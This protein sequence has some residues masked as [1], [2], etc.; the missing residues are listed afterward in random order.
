MNASVLSLWRTRVLAIALALV[1]AC[2]VSLLMVSTASAAAPTMTAVTADTNTDGTI[3]R[4]TITF[5]EAADLDD[6][7]AGDGFTSLALSAS[8]AI[9]NGDYNNDSTTTLTL[10]N[11]TGCTSE[12]TAITPT[13]TYTAVANCTTAMSICDAA[14]ANQMANGTNTTSTDGAG[15]VLISATPSTAS[16]GNS[17]TVDVVFT[18]SEAIATASDT[19]AVSPNVTHTETWSNSDKTITLDGAWGAG[20]NTVTFTAV[21]AA[22]GS[23]TAFAG[24]QT[25]D[26]TVASPFTFY[27]S[28]STASS[29][30]STTT[31]S[32]DIDVTSPNGG[33]SYSAGE[34]VAITWS[35]S[36]TTS[37]MSAT[38]IN[39]MWGSDSTSQVTIVS[40]TPNDGSYMWTVPALDTAY[41]K[42]QVVGTDLVESMATDESDDYFTIGSPAAEGADDEAVDEEE[43]TEDAQDESAEDTSDV[44]VSPVTG[45]EESISDVAYGDYIRSE[46]FDTVYYIDMD[47]EGDL[48]R[49]PFMDAQTFMT[50]QN[51]WDG[52]MTVTDATLPTIELGAPM[53]PKAGVVLVKIV[54]IAKVYAVE[55]D[56]TLR[57]ITS[58]D[59]AEEMYGSDWADYVIDIADTLFPRFETGDDLD[60][61]EDVDTSDMKTRVEVNS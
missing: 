13:V 52:V 9:A 44:G 34:V 46:Y 39:L 28:T 58:E 23:V 31:A 37:A 29:G 41:A 2:A 10:S 22:S 53:L 55:G 30:A 35:S 15:P 40:G 19:I 18:F 61:A 38:N 56:G 59:V 25:G 26:A 3:D 17:R 1:G 54:S 32:Y 42:I 12:N 51:D 5:S 60:S 6:G 14:G 49:R 20:Y 48:V 27:T 43:D 50:W 11:L 8:C 45:E 33:E 24:A 21:P 16:V 47:S 7:N 36:A 4:I 57:W